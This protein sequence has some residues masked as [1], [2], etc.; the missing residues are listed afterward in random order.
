[1]AS[2]K[3]SLSFPGILALFFTA[4]TG[5]LAIF[6][7]HGTLAEGFTAKSLSLEPYE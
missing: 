4:S 6:V 1:M 7:E 5:L 3:S 2:N